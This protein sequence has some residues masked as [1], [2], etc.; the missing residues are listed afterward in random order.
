MHPVFAPL[1]TFK[2]AVKYFPLPSVNLLIQNDRGEYLYLLRNNQPAKG[3]WW[4]PGGRLL[5]GETI[6][7]ASQ[8]I[9]AQETGL[10]ADIVSVS[11]R[12]LEELWDT[13]VYAPSEL[14]NYDP[15]T[16]CVHYWT[17]AVHLRLSGP[18]SIHMDAQSSEAR[19]FRDLPNHH[20]Y[21]RRYFEICNL[22]TAITRQ[23]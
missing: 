15:S 10:S 4:V 22:P 20:P 6:V 12:L 16:A 1:D 9:L 14:T 2:A 13:S 23:A 17:T 5:N 11:D 7:E 21:L 19:W 8:R 18:A 3:L